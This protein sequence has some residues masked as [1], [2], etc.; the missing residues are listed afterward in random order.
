MCWP[1]WE[2]T[3]YDREEPKLTTLDLARIGHFL[4]GI[5]HPLWIP[6]SGSRDR[7]MGQTKVEL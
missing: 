6:T 7:R 4:L 3:T 2:G 5:R 1:S